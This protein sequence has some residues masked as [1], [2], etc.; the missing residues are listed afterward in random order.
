MAGLTKEGLTIKRQDEVIQSLKGSAVPIFQ[1]LVP[2]G[3]IVDTSDDSTL[4]RIIGLYSDPLSELW[5][6][7]QAVY[8]A[9]DI[10]SAYGLSLDDLVA[11]KGL[12]RR[13][14]AKTRA[15]VYLYGDLGAYLGNWAIARSSTTAEKFQL[16]DGV[17][18]SPDNCHGVG[19][20]VTEVI[21]NHD[22]F[23]RYRFRQQG[24]WLYLIYKTKTNPSIGGIIDEFISL[25]NSNTDLKAHQ[26]DGRI[27]VEG[28]T[29]LSL[30]EFEVS[31][32]FK[33]DKVVA[34]GKMSASKDGAIAQPTGTIDRIA[35]PS[36]GWDSV[37]NPIPAVTGSLEETDE[38]LR[39]R[40]KNSRAI[41]ATNI[42]EAL[43]SKLLSLSGVNSAVIYENETDF[44]DDIGLPPHSFMAIVDG[45]LDS[46]VAKAIW[47]NKP[48]GISSEGDVEVDITDS[49]GYNRKIRF[50]RPQVKFI[51]IRMELERF[52]NYPPTGDEDIKNSLLSF[53]EKQ[54]TGQDLIFSR[55][56]TPINQ[57]TGHQVNLL[58]VSEDGTNWKSSNITAGLGVKLSLRPEDITIV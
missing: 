13:F 10:D 39:A 3:D 14:A 4:G 52:T 17:L 20:L 36:F 45:G 43:Y 53:M 15:E 41:G 56:Y 54:V 18:L 7:A 55:L 6:L 27:W 48:A 22:Y 28:E 38:E 42:I 21:P 46:E 12:T 29:E 23:I 57:T 19:F 26:V 50:T 34:V 44:T 33:I 24:D 58:E 25:V 2:V 49:Q 11:Y 8:L 51:H 32:G 16:E 5:E 31:S 9:F 37:T 47:L 40:F 30:F 35:T 1:D